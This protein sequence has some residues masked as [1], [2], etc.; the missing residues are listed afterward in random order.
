[1]KTS[2][3]SPGIFRIIGVLSN[4]EDFAKEYNC[5]K[6]SPMNPETKCTIW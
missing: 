6:N 2:V 1:M 5:P 3:H 4:S